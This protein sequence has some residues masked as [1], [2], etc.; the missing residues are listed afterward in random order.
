MAGP[1]GALPPG[2]GFPQLPFGPSGPTPLAGPKIGG[3]PPSLPDRLPGGWT[4]PVVKH[5]WA[6]PGAN[7]VSGGVGGRTVNVF[8][9]GRWGWGY[10]P[11]FWGGWVS[12]SEGGYSN[13][14][15]SSG[16]TAA[17]QSTDSSASAQ[18]QEQN[19]SAVGKEDAANSR[20]E[21][22][23][24]AK[25][26]MVVARLAFQKGDYAGAQK[27]CEQALRL[28]PGDANLHEF[29]A[30]CQFAQGNYKG[31]AATLH[32]VLAAGP[33]WDWNTLSSFYPGA[34]TY[35][36]QLRALEQHVKEHPKDAAGH[37]VLAYHYLVLDERDAAR[38]QLR[39]VVNAQPTDRVSAGILAALNKANNGNDEEP[40]GKPAPGR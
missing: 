4:P 32:P 20:E 26:R 8:A 22:P 3:G 5:G 1:A 10:R 23:A 6:R 17:G 11:S 19:S 37:F 16:G 14:Y 24:E 38:G 40:A 12:G 15:S 29:R 25:Q 18:S 2:G 7:I 36:K 35:T 28:L 33:G 39:E 9:G 21:I 34:A 30:L 13:P 27:Q 31:A